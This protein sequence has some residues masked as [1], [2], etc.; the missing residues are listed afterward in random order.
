MKTNITLLGI[1]GISI[2]YIVSTFF[3]KAHAWQDGQECT[4]EQPCVTVTPSC[5]PTVTPTEEVTP[6]ATPEATLTPTETP[7]PTAPPAGHGDGRSDG[8]SDGLSSCPDCTKAPVIP[9]A[10]PDTGRG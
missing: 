9:L 10:A 5:T 8:R 1:V 2:V 4:T 6:T 7:V 3:F